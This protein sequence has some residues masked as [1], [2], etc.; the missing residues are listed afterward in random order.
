MVRLLRQLIS[1][2]A[3][4]V[5]AWDKFQRKDLGYFIYD[6]ETSSA[7]SSLKFSVN[8]VDK[9]FWD[10]KDDLRKLHD[11]ERELCKDNPQGV[12]HLS[13]SK[14]EGELHPSA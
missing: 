12:S 4:I 9:A 3:D 2:L 11:L 14:L 8:A 13:S 1:S 10:L 6:G 5:G 7:S